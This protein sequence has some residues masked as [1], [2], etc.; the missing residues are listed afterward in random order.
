MNKK[1]IALAVAAA[2]FSGVASAA[3]VFSNDTSS[4]AIGGRAEARLA[5][6]KVNSANDKGYSTEFQDNSRARLNVTGTTQISDSLYAVGFF[7]TEYASEKG[8]ESSTRHVY[9]GVGGDF[10]RVTFGLQDGSV[11]VI[12]DF[13]DIMAY[14]GAEAGG[15]IDVA[16]RIENNLA[17]VGSFD[18][19]SVKANY[20]FN[21]N[22]G[23]YDLSGYSAS[24]IY[25]FDMG[26]SLGAGFGHQE[27]QNQATR[28]K[29]KEDQ[30][31]LAASYT[32][33]DFYFAG[34][35][36]NFESKESG[37]TGKDKGRGFELAAAYTMDK[38][39]FS[40]TY[41]VLESKEYGERYTDE[42]DAIA[43]D[44]THRFN[45]NFRTYISY[46]FNNLSA[47][48]DGNTKVDASD[49]FVLGARYDF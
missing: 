41:G 37:V 4:L 42:A 9:A 6:S 24:A 7:E 46:K 23:V 8:G 5:N 11:G 33:G 48:K 29:I 27:D 10:G 47:G 22:E 3:E 40:V 32:M 28:S 19:L 38:T 20:V 2:S 15:K 36:Q 1:L 13:T 18:A 43:I 45:S 49:E 21:N 31:Y 17:Y 12:T 26:L 14:H 35:Y 44:A 34:L 39:T 30:F 16:D 25:D